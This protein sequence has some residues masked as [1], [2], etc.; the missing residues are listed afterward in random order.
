MENSLVQNEWYESLIDDLQDILVEA[1]FTSRWALVE[2]YHLL[3]TRLL[4]EYDNFER[5]KIY[6]QKITTAVA[7]SLGKSTRTIERAVQFARLYPDLNMLPEG[8][9]VSWNKVVV[10]YLTEGGKKEPKKKLCPRCG[11]EL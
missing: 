3:G 5:Q 1:E 4:E 9:N 6:G 2:G 11:Y 7:E 8:K 10:N